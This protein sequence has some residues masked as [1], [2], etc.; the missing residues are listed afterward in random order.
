LAGPDDVDGG[1]LATEDPLPGVVAADAPAG[2]VGMD[3]LALAEGLQGQLVS[4]L[5]PVG[6]AL[7]GTPV[8]QT[9]SARPLPGRRASRSA[10]KAG[11]RLNAARISQTFSTKVGW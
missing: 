11:L 5:G 10:C 2:F 3:H 4:R 9:C 6:Q 7:F 1:L 8:W